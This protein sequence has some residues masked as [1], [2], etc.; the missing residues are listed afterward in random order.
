MNNIEKFIENL[1]FENKLNLNRDDKKFPMGSRLSISLS[2]INGFITFRK[3]QSASISVFN[4]VYVIEADFTSDC[5]SQ[6]EIKFA[7]LIDRVIKKSQIRNKRYKLM[8]RENCD[9]IEAILSELKFEYWHTL[10]EVNFIN[11]SKKLRIE[12]KS[13]YDFEAESILAYLVTFL[14]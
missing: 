14:R 1:A 8:A 11:Q 9:L 13:Y 4:T 6:F 12:I 3:I 10:R 7:N 2:S 5:S